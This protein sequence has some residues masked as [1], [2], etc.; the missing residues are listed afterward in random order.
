MRC[1]LGLY[2]RLAPSHCVPPFRGDAR[3]VARSRWDRARCPTPARRAR[4]FQR[5]T[6]LR[7]PHALGASM[8]AV[9]SHAD[10]RT[11]MCPGCSGAIDIAS[12]G[13]AGSGLR[14]SARSSCGHSGRWSLV[15]GRSSCRLTCKD[16]CAREAS[17]LA[18]R[19]FA[20][21][22]TFSYTPSYP[23]FAFPFRKGTA[24]RRCEK[25]ST[26]RNPHTRF[27]TSP[28]QFFQ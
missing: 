19:D 22:E 15:A 8:S 18:R 27:R 17:A 12:D 4:G 7:L 9:A 28:T 21:A 14:D 5:K 20:L 16:L 10:R 26:T 23:Q 25:R 3:S 11:W 1:W 6:R 24:A 13:R 2:R